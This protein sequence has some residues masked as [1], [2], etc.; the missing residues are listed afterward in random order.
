[1][2]KFSK[3]LFA[4]DKANHIV[5]GAIIASLCSVVFTPYSSLIVVI[6]L[7]L[8]K[9]LYDKLSKRGTPELLDVLATVFGGLLVVLPMY[10]SLITK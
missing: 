7:A 3:L 8:A 5:Y 10:Y 4:Q 2:S 1:M 9:E 6:L